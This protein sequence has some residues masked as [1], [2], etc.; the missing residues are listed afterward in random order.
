MVDPTATWA[1]LAAGLAQSIRMDPDAFSR[2]ATAGANI[3]QT[4]ANTAKQQIENEQ[5]AWLNRQTRAAADVYHAISND[6]GSINDQKASEYMAKNPEL[7]GF[8]LG[9]RGQVQ[10]QAEKAANIARTQVETATGAV[11]LPAIQ[12]RAGY[13]AQTIQGLPSAFQQ[14]S[15]F[16]SGFS[17]LSPADKQAASRFAGA[18]GA[19]AGGDV[20]KSLEGMENAKEAQ[21][22]AKAQQDFLAG[23]TGAIQRGEADIQALRSG[24]FMKEALEGG[25]QATSTD[26]SHR[27]ARQSQTSW[28]Q[29]QNAV[30]NAHGEGF[31]NVYSGNI[32]G[33]MQAKSAF[34][35]LKTTDKEIHDM[36]KEVKTGKVLDK[37]DFRGQ[38]MALSN[39]PIVADNISTES[40]RSAFMSV[41]RT[42]PS[43]QSI[44]R[45]SGG[46]PIHFLQSAASAKL[47][48]QSQSRVLD[49]LGSITSTQ[50]KTGKAFQDLNQYRTREERA[51]NSAPRI[52]KPE[53][54]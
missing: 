14:A 22:R 45:E 4:G 7:S 26:L 24:G 29:E 17:K 12:A 40:G 31:G 38:V 34:D 43:L 37:D 47:S 1:P 32:S 50:L 23:D 18:S 25:R 15:P 46:N 9:M 11:K 48:A 21:I 6:D 54:Y 10:G 39:A 8:V 33:Y 51:K 5:Q 53:D 13:E 49:V 19:A 52:L 30:Q 41:I 27:S 20:G 44:W 35:W 36:S 16:Q 2:A 28:E 3:A 42:D